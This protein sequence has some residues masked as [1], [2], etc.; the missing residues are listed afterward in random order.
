MNTAFTAGAGLRHIGLLSAALIA[1]AGCG[2]G[3]GG[4]GGG[5]TPTPTPTNSAPTANA[6]ADQ[7]VDGGDT[8]TLSG[9]GSD[10]DAGDTLTFSWSQIEGPS[11]T[12]SDPN[13]ASTTFT[14]PTAAVSDQLLTFRLSVSDGSLN[15]FD[16]VDVT[17]RGTGSGGG[18]TACS[19]TASVCGKVQYEFV[20]PNA[21]CRGLDFAAVQLRPVR[22]ATVQLL[23]AG[24]STVLAS[25]VT[26]D[27]G[28]YEFGGIANG[29]N[30]QVRVLAELK[31]TGG[32]TWDVEIRDNVVAGQASPPALDQRPLYALDGASFTVS[33][34]ASIQ[35]L[36]AATGWD[37]TS[38]TGARAAAPFSVL[39]SIYDGMEL[40]LSV[41]A[42]ATFAPLDAYWSANN[43]LVTTGTNID[44]GELGA[45]FYRGDIDSLFLVGDPVNGQDTEEF[46][47]HVIVHEWGHYFED[48]FSRSD[49]RGGPHSIGDRLDMRL[50]WGEGW[51]TALAGMA[52]P[53]PLYCDTNFANNNTG[54]FGI[55]AED[56]GY[57][58]RGWYDE[59]SVVRFLYDLFDDVNDLNAAKD[60]NNI[61]D[62][63]SIGFA[64][65][66]NTMI[67]SQRSTEAFTTVFSFAT[68]L[69]ASLD[70]AD[71][72]L[73]DDQL[74]KFDMDAAGLDIWGS[75][76]N[77]T[78]QDVEGNRDVL[79]V[80]TDLP[81]D[82]T[83]VNIC[84]NDD[85]DG[86]GD[87]NK[88]ATRRFLRAD[89]TTPGIYDVSVVLTGSTPALAADD[90][91]DERDQSDPDF[92]M[93]RDGILVAI[94]TSGEA[95]QEIF[96]TQTSLAVGTH[97]I[98]LNEFRY[99]DS[100]SPAN[101]PNQVCWDV[102]MAPQ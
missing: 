30:A 24:T 32:P 77:A 56:G 39:D 31:R 6:G 27:A 9:T 58:A 3:G 74:V 78:I 96:P 7:T 2:G 65:I 1:L 70:P 92:R 36:T 86:D 57:D 5:S 28:D 48:N 22:Q 15:R 69:R 53:S 50:A 61:G 34:T 63:V 76:Q 8:V 12:L 102:S 64:P 98:D 10:P 66:Y 72:V 87:G 4:G 19:G 33:S 82:G 91:A 20:P 14:A 73:M 47:T 52:L 37:G 97:V 83:P 59:I 41:D 89:V 68:Q 80:Y 21:N 75:N 99:A 54:G 26:D 25:T 18:T 90:P 17:V 85:W 11:V 49:S 23:Q 42:T 40:I 55:G 16:N 43:A 88:L 95:N 84:A 94:G 29:T 100:E 71:Q 13:A 38:Y 79:P 67:S 93:Y 101:F 44:E 62:P 60:P 46:D 45:S 35:D 51:A 81:T